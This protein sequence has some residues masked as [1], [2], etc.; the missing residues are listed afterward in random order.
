MPATLEA[1]SYGNLIPQ[2][3]QML[4]IVLAS[5]EWP[6]Y[7]AFQSSLS[8]E[9][10]ARAIA[11]YLC[12]EHGPGIPNSN[13]KIL[14]DSYEPASEILEQLHSF[15]EKR[16]GELKRQGT[17]ATDLLI[18]Y[19]GHGGFNGGNRYF[20]AVRRTNRV[21]PVGTSITAESLGHLIRERA[22]DLRC[23]LVLDCCFA[24]A[25]LTSFMSSGPLEVAGQQLAN[26]LPPDGDSFARA[27][28]RVPEYG[29]GL[30][31][32]SGAHDPAKALPNQ[33]YTMFTGAVLELLR[34]GHPGAPKWLS[35]DHIQY[36]VKENLKEHFPEEAVFPQIH[37]PM[38]RAGRV[39]LVQLFPNPA[40]L[41]KKGEPQQVDPALPPVPPPEPSSSA[42]GNL[43]IGRRLYSAGRYEEA[44]H[45]FALAAEQ[46]SA[47]A[48]NRLGGCYHQGHGVQQ[49]YTE[50][51]R[52]YRTAGD[53]GNADA[54][55]NLGFLH[56]MGL[57][58][59]QSY[60]EAA[61]LFK[62]ASDQ[63]NAN[64]RAGLGHLYEKGWG[65]RQSYLDA[66]RLY[67]LAAHQ[68]NAFAQFC[69][70]R[71]YENGIGVGRSIP[72]ALNWYRRA[73]RQKFK[74]AEVTLQRLE[75]I[76]GSNC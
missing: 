13:V 56:M 25:A 70:G 12:D 51:A 76:G 69:L 33:Q 46:G 8:F 75:N 22:R 45:F 28:G 42:E 47:A 37:A 6:D 10:S 61:R 40:R 64:A 3:E 2:P 20:L 17:A 72:L 48:Q 29:V 68:E 4:A 66:A 53:L 31:C 50:A 57:G 9:R 52:C 19:I 41:A 18:Y 21:D 38:Q 30:L 60:A 67:R 35:L 27:E 55:Y 74:E 71:L 32:A 24:A 39:D 63:G 5:S 65:V 26:A 44:A 7:P 15:V 43:V 11:A 23:Y 34:T 16:R 36:F 62:K 73:A 59:P 54:E 1:P 49:S 14:I 58:T